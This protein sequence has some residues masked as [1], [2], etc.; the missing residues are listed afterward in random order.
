MD[1]KLKILLDSFSET[2]GWSSWYVIYLNAHLSYFYWVNLGIQ[3][4]QSPNTEYDDK[5]MHGSY[6]LVLNRCWFLLLEFFFC[7]WTSLSKTK[8]WL[9]RCCNG[10]LITRLSAVCWSLVWCAPQRPIL[11]CWRTSLVVTFDIHVQHVSNRVSGWNM[12]PQGASE[13]PMQW[14]FG[15][16]LLLVQRMGPAHLLIACLRRALK[17][18]FP[19]PCVCVWWWRQGEVA[20]LKSELRTT[21]KRSLWAVFAR[22]NLSQQQNTIA[23]CDVTVSVSFLSTRAAMGNQW[24]QSF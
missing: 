22:H 8:S 5:R 1:L 13:T 9:W 15:C 17:S 18:R 11:H 21:L 20:M 14:H 6:T 10:P 7:L 16:A 24:V 4:W 23:G 12:S 2:N 19:T 3:F